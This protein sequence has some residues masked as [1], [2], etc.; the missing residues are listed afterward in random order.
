MIVRALRVPP[1][2]FARGTVLM[3]ITYLTH[4]AAFRVV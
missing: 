4:P 1:P 2:R 3:A